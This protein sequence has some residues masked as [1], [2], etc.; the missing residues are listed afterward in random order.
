MDMPIHE[1]SGEITSTMITELGRGYRL[2]KPIQAFLF[3]EPLGFSAKTV[4]LSLIVQGHGKTRDE[5]VQS[6]RDSV[7]GQFELL[8]KARPEVMSADAYPLFAQLN[9]YVVY[10]WNNFRRLRTKMKLPNFEG[11]KEYTFGRLGRELSRN[12]YFHG[13]HHTRDDVLP[14]SEK[15]ATM[16]GIYGEDLVLL[17]TAAVGHDAGFLWRYFKNEPLGVKYV[18]DETPRFGY[19]GGQIERIGQIIMPTQLQC[20][21][22]KLVQL[23]DPNDLL[24]LLI[25]DSDMDHLGREDF[26]VK[27]ENLRR[28]WREYGMPKTLKEW[29]QIQLDFQQGHIYFTNAAKSL[30]NEGKE[31]NI[32]ELREALGLM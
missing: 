18:E 7:V 31:K 32:R 12:L 25:C 30:R 6:L 29:L 24:Q 28:E 27:G 26:F 10:E 11:F 2:T 23:P 22:G 16:D 5:A 20:I 1:E 19:S 15:L 9:K 8:K 4:D 3:K 17:K 21:D 14:A 13:V